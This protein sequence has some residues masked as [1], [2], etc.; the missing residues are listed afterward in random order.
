M[1][2]SGQYCASVGP[3]G[4]AVLAENAQ[5]VG[6]GADFL[7]ADRKAAAGYS[8]FAAG[9]LNIVPGSETPDRAVANNL[10]QMGT[11][12]VSLGNKQELEPN[13]FLVPYQTAT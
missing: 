1:P 2:F 6:F 10:T 5:R 13:V 4:W 7:S 8:I 12:R 3:Q 9:T 11:L